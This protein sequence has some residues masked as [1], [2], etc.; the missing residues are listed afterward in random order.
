MEM[1]NRVVLCLK[2]FKFM[3][4][5][6]VDLFIPLCLINEIIKYTEMDRL[7]ATNDMWEN[8]DGCGLY[9]LQPGRYFASFQSIN[10]ISNYQS[11][12]I[13]Y[14]DDLNQWSK[15]GS[16]NVLFITPKHEVEYPMCNYFGLCGIIKQ[17]TFGFETAFGGYKFQW[18]NNRHKWFKFAHLWYN[19]MPNMLHY[20]SKFNMVNVH[21]EIKP[22]QFADCLNYYRMYSFFI[23]SPHC[24]FFDT[25]KEFSCVSTFAANFVLSLPVNVGLYC[26]IDICKK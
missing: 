9:T 10:K 14:T 26:I 11:M 12:R 4:E 24:E 7:P 21:M 3:D 25:T 8:D 20:F 18:Q 1:V 22:N 19:F 6:D 15:G 17:Y 2:L 5:Y 23:S 13:K 16:I